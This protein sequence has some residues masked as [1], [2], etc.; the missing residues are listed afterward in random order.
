MVMQE[1][2]R[3]MGTGEQKRAELPIRQLSSEVYG[4]VM[5]LKSAIIVCCQLGS[6]VQR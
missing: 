4:M 6:E 5:W 3:D 1:I 2:R